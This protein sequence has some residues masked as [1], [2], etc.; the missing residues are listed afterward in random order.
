MVSTALATQ[1]RAMAGRSSGGMAAAA[2]TG[3]YEGFQP[4]AVSRTI[5]EVLELGGEGSSSS[6]SPE[7]AA[8]AIDPGSVI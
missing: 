8:L 2:S 7:Q 5:P 4:E 6:S 1:L 3:C